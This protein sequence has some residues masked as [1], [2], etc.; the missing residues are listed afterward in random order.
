MDASIIL[1]RSSCVSIR[2]SLRCPSRLGHNWSCIPSAARHVALQIVGELDGRLTRA[3]TNLLARQERTDVLN[4]YFSG[5]AGFFVV[6]HSAANRCILC[7]ARS[8]P[9]TALPVHDRWSGC[10]HA[11]YSAG[12]GGAILRDRMRIPGGACFAGL[13]STASFCIENSVIATSAATG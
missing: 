5:L 10:W 11:G 7:C 12:H 1:R 3:R 9:G 4:S 8:L 2:V 6:I 13:A